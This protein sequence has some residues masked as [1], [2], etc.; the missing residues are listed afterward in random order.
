MLKEK[1]Y[2]SEVKTNKECNDEA[3]QAIFRN[4]LKVGGCLYYEEI[5]IHKKAV[6]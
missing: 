3:P 4:T 5:I 2:R 1:V 6:Q